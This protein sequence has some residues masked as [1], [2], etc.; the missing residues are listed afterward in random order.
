M[1]ALA[2]AGSFG[3]KVPGMADGTARETTAHDI[4]GG[5]VTRPGRLADQRGRG[6][7]VEGTIDGGN[8]LRWLE[9]VTQL[10]LAVNVGTIQAH[11]ALWART[12]VT[13]ARR[14]RT[15]DARRPKGVVDPGFGDGTTV[16][17][18][19]QHE[20]TWVGPAKDHM[21]GT[22]DARAQA[23][24]GE[25]RPAGCRG[26]TV[27]HGQGKTA[28]TERLATDVGGMRGLPPD[29]QEGT[30]EQARQAN[31]HAFQANP[32]NAVVVHQWQ[33]KDEGPGGKPVFLP[34]AP[35]AQPWQVCEDEDERRRIEHCGRKVAK[36]PWERGPPRRTTNG[37][38]GCR[39]SSPGG[40]ARWRLRIGG[41]VRARR[42]EVSPSAGNAG[43]PSAWSRPEPRGSAWP[44]GT[45]ASVISLAA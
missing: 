39:W 12:L 27:R 1:R 26:Q 5:Q 10:P 6:H 7:A 16:W 35:V 22:A 9:A 37:P 8:V 31:R 23:R 14:H 3:A 30:P 25:G 34:Q 36:Q 15:G 13:Q 24:A 21:A 11:E 29:D 19:E 20:R 43:G 41:R 32:L 17:W 18:L 44:R 40:C 2:K 33:G 45:M 42:G 38:Y 28:G 4:G